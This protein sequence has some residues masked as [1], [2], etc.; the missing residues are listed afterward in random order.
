MSVDIDNSECEEDIKS[1]D[2]E[3][4]QHVRMK[5]E[6]NT[7]HQQKVL[8][9]NTYAGVPKGTSTEG[10]NLNYE[11]PL[12]S[13]QNHNSENVPTPDKIHFFV[14]GIQPT[15][16]GKRLNIMYT[17]KVKATYSNYGAKKLK[18]YIP[19]LIQAPQFEEEK[20]PEVECKN[21]FY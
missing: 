1:I 16:V 7:F 5:G 21:N 11:V 2:I 12:S 10:Y 3:L 17:I 15:T 4:R 13:A 9:K 19:V 18:T 14:Y 20:Q 6:I 8:L